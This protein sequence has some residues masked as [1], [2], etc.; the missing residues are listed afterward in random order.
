MPKAAVGREASSTIWCLASA[1]GKEPR[2]ASRGKSRARFA[3]QFPP[4]FHPY[5]IPLPP[6]PRGNA[7]GEAFGEGYLFPRTL[8]SSMVGVENSGAS[9]ISVG[10][11]QLFA[12]DRVK[13][14]QG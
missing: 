5:T 8:L 4:W 6:L 10:L 3:A 14:S 9:N 13:I 2:A 12:P 7:L 11:P 1:E